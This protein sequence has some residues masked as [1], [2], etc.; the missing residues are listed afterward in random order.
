MY[1]H[2]LYTEDNQWNELPGLMC[3]TI[4][5]NRDHDDQCGCKSMSM[6]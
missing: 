2:Q 1:I 3:A 6:K 5:N 4:L